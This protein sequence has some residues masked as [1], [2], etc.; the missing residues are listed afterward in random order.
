MTKSGAVLVHAIHK[1]IVQF[2]FAGPATKDH[3]NDDN[4][5]ERQSL[6]EFIQVFFWSFL[7]PMVVPILLLIGFVMMYVHRWRRIV[8]TA[9]TLHQQALEVYIMLEQ[10]EMNNEYWTS[11]TKKKKKKQH[12]F[13]ITNTDTTNG[14]DVNVTG[15]TIPITPPPTIPNSLHF[16]IWLHRSKTTEEL[17]YQAIQLDPLYLPPILSLTA[18][19]LYHQGNA[20]AALY[21][22]DQYN[23]HSL[24][25]NTLRT[26]TTTTR[27]VTTTS[28]SNTCTSDD[29]KK[30]KK[31]NGDL[32]PREE[33]NNGIAAATNTNTN[34]KN[35]TLECQRKQLQLDAIALQ[36][37]YGWDMIPVS[38]RQWEYLSVTFALNHGTMYHHH[39]QQQQ[40]KEQYHP[41]PTRQDLTHTVTTT[42][43]TSATTKEKEL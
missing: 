31:K 7:V 10:H 36:T 33:N 17:L 6:S 4:D 41:S 22:L 15:T 19:Y 18:Y 30:K 27:S 39:Q 13:R 8:P 21:V 20:K 14:M 32:N 16:M 40:Q 12:P 9:A 1:L 3:D 35:R 43:T 37:G 11:T 25:P 5:N 2:V 28:T 42:T 34:W 23:N 26:T 24:T 29:D 38:L